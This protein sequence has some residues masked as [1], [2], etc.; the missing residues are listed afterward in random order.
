MLFELPAITGKSFTS[1]SL[2][3]GGEELSSN[4]VAMCLREQFSEIA[5]K[6]EN[7]PHMSFRVAIEFSKRVNLI[8]HCFEKFFRES[9]CNIRMFV[10][11]VRVFELFLT[12]VIR[13]SNFVT[14]I[15]L[16]NLSLKLNQSQAVYLRV[17]SVTET[18][19]HSQN[20]NYEPTSH[21]PTGICTVSVLYPG[22]PL[23][24]PARFPTS[25]FPHYFSGRK[26]EKLWNVSSFR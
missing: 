7:I 13:V 15:E 24:F 3:L 22:K 5:W 4:V 12:L 9:C 10:V 17:K 18:L 16:F 8:F 2:S 23:I 26:E 25:S 14:Q 20:P 1:L 21:Q 19:Q 11:S 6:I